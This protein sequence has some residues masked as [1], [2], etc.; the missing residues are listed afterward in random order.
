VKNAFAAAVVLALAC[1]SADAQTVWRD[2][3]HVGSER[4]RYLRFAHL[5]GGADPWNA[6]DS[7]RPVP[8]LRLLRPQILVS[9]NTGFPWR[10]PD[11]PVWQGRGL[12][13]AATVGAAAT[14]GFVSA[15]I[16]P[17]FGYAA[18]QSF[19]LENPNV[20][21]FDGMRPG[22]IDQ[23]QRFGANRFTTIDAGESFLRFA[24]LGMSLALSNEKLFWG[25]GVRHAIIFGAD[26]PGFP[27][28]SLGTRGPI[29]TPLGRFSSEVVYAKLSGS[30]WVPAAQSRTRLGSGIRFE[31][32]PPAVPIDVGVA[33]FYHRFWPQV[34]T[35]RLLKVP[36]GSLLF[37]AQD[38]AGDSADN[39]LASAF[40]RLRLAHARTEVYGEFARN[41]RSRGLRDLKLEPEHNAAWLL[42]MIRTF[43][44]GVDARSFWTARFETAS[45]RV[46]AIQNIP[47]LQTTFYEHSPVSAGHTQRGMLLGTPL[48]DRSAGADLAIDR[49][50]ARGRIGAYVMERE[51]PDDIAVGVS[52]DRARAQWDVGAELV[53]FTS[54]GDLSFRGGSVFDINRFVGTTNANVYLRLL[55]QAIGHRALAPHSSGPYHQ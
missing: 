14:F 35:A 1:R 7:A 33:R 21:F 29:R 15:R 55:V 54:W 30:R 13:A 23:P 22:T 48:I 6:R 51:M 28:V 2:E 4:A 43:S 17:V 11:L 5:G 8:R 49:W 40:F 47:R 41:D 34:V 32:T 12:N 37:D 50:D 53:R 42:G 52:A 18:N 46:S 26:G 45:G 25:P 20:G 19:R 10:S 39:Q 31:W 3:V 44:I 36:F 24:G 9:A 16:E 38:Q 27:H